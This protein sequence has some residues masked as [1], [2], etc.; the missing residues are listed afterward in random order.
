[1]SMA[2]PSTWRCPSAATGTTA[3]RTTSQRTAPSLR[4]TTRNASSIGSC[5]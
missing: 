1:M 3:P 4:R 2:T 5:P